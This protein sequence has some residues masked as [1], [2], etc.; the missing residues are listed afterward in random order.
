MVIDFYGSRQNTRF[1][2]LRAKCLK[3][4]Q[5][6]PLKLN[7]V[8]SVIYLNFTRNKLFLLQFLNR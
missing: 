8:K 3:F 5:I 2:G 4:K 1:S 7:A 6:E